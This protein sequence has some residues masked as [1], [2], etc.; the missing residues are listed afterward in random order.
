[1][2]LQEVTGYIVRRET[3]NAAKKIARTSGD[4]GVIEQ[5]DLERTS[6]IVNGQKG[7]INFGSVQKEANYG[8][9]GDAVTAEEFAAYLQKSADAGNQVVTVILGSGQKIKI[10]PIERNY[11]SRSFASSPVVKMLTSE[12][13]EEVP[14]RINDHFK[15]GGYSYEDNSQYLLP[16]EFYLR[17]KGDCNDYSIFAHYILSKSGYSPRF[18]LMYGPQEPKPGE[19]P[20]TADICAY[21]DKKGL[22]NYIDNNGL[23]TIKAASLD[24]LLKTEFPG[25]KP[26]EL[27]VENGIVQVTDEVRRMFLPAK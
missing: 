21:S 16:W 23:H 5:G 6:L 17:M 25:S 1:M 24:R 9:G 7:P 27:Q 8:L 13:R 14:N 10:T 22:W 20:E 19:L 12:P 11:D 3:L 26:I 4:P 18:I 2:G 15:N